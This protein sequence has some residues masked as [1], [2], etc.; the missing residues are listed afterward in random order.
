MGLLGARGKM[1]QWVC[2]LMTTEFEKWATLIS[3]VNREDPLEPLLETDVVIDFSSPERMNQLARLALKQ[4]KNL[5]TF[6]VGSTGWDHQTNSS[7]EQLGQKTSVLVAANF[8]IGIF[9]LSKILKQFSPLLQKAGY[10]PVIVET[11]HCHKKDSPSG[12]AN[13]LRQSMSTT[14]D[15]STHLDIPIHSI[16]AGEVI[17][18]HEISFFGTADKITL[19]HFAQDRSIFARGA[20]QA[21]LWLAERQKEEPEIKGV[22]GI[23]HYFES[24]KGAG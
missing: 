12:T 6:V 11:H 20:I 15:E 7:L 19:G 16:R 8:S 22:F 21:A 24:L 5:P 17:G 9:T 23:E 2:E 3:A 10:S 13:Y 4:A 14:M 18:D 1:G